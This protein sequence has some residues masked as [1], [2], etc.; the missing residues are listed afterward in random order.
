[1]SGPLAAPKTKAADL[2]LRAQAL[3]K[4]TFDRVVALVKQHGE[5]AEEVMIDHDIMT[6]ADLLRAL[7]A[8]YRTNYL[9]TEKLS[10]RPT[11]RAPPCRW[12]RVASRRHWASSR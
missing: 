5:R 7:S 10:R 12:S 11:S 6:E 3:P 9:S 4:Q 1:M 8:V 2:L